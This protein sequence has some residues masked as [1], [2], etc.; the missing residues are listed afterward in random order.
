V[1]AATDQYVVETAPFRAFVAAA[2]LIVERL[3]DPAGA[4]AELRGPFGRL[5]RDDDWLPEELA[6]PAVSG[7]MG[8]GI[9]S[10]LL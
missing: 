6:V 9:G 5:L 10:Y 1:S 8:G 2:R 7:G 4:I 3:A